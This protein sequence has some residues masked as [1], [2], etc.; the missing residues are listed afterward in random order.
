MLR[1]R[2][3]S[4]RPSRARFWSEPPRFAV[5]SSGG[6]RS[7]ED[8]RSEAFRLLA[9]MPTAGLAADARKREDGASAR[10]GT[11]TLGSLLDEHPARAGVIE[12]LGYFQIAH[13]EGHIVSPAAEEEIV[14]P[15][16]RGERALALTVP[17]VRFIST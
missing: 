11:V 6:A 15:S 8:R 16:A 10:H 5:A 13:D 12:V 9:E 17:L 2:V 1:R 14:L 7:D 4:R 3:P